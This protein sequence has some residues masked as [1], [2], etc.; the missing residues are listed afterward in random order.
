MLGFEMP[1]Y[2]HVPLLVNKQG[3]RLSKR[4]KDASLDQMLEEYK[5]PEAILGHIAYVG[6]LLEREEAL[7]PSEIL[8]VFNASDYVARIKE[9][10][11]LLSPIVWS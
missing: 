11:G 5:T 9:E 7:T 6:K 2:A 4:D 3:K 8:D 10:V 1:D